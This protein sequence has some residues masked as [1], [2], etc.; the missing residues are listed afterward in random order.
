MEA[1]L[2]ELD[3]AVARREKVAELLISARAAVEADRV[4]W[5][6]K[7]GAP[8]V[9]RRRTTAALKAACARLEIG[10]LPGEH[11]PAQARPAGFLAA[12]ARQNA[13][14]HADAETVPPGRLARDAAA[15]RDR[16][17]D[18]LG[19]DVDDVDPGDS[20]DPLGRGR[21]AVDDDDDEE[22]AD[23]AHFYR[24]SS[25]QREFNSLTA[26]AYRKGEIDRKVTRVVP[27]QLLPNACQPEHIGLGIFHM[28]APQLEMGLPLPPCPRCG[29]KSV[30]K[31]RVSLNG[32]CP[33]RRVYAAEVDEWLGGYSLCCGI[34]HDKK[35]ELKSKLEHLDED[36]DAEEYEAAR[37][38]GA[39]HGRPARRRLS[40]RQLKRRIG[41]RNDVK[42][43]RRR[44]RRRRRRSSRRRRRQRR[45]RRRS[46]SILVSPR[47]RLGSEA[48][49]AH[50]RLI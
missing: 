28:H 38:R 21:T 4:K 49:L 10:L 41:R 11:Q 26:K 18:Q 12:S 40:C 44:R 8:T 48:D 29:W 13:Q 46:E 9:E 1:V 16:N 23:F 50:S 2:E 14:H 32:L 22:D 7:L 35:E 33:A 3:E 45:P 17:G 24:V 47:L 34:C 27:P 39:V 15:A 43:P 30:D 19:V 42:K 31:Q 36:E 6:G 37:A 5:L 20:G 25:N